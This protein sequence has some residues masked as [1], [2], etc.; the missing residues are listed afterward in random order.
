MAEGEKSGDERLACDEEQPSTSSSRKSRGRV[1]SQSARERGQEEA[2]GSG[3]SVRDR[4]RS[5]HECRWR[6]ESEPDTEAPP[7]P[8]F[9]P[10]RTPG[11]QPPLNMGN[12]S[13]L[14]IFSSFFDTAV[15]NL[16][17]HNTNKNAAGKIAQGKRF[18]WRD[19]TAED[20]KKFIGMLLFMSV[21]HLPKLSDY[22]R[23][24]T[25]FQVPFPATIMPRDQFMSILSCIHMSDPEEDKI[26]EEKKGT[27]DYDRLHRVRP[28]MDLISMRCKAIYHPRQHLSVD[29]RMVATKARLGIKQY[30][31]AKPTKWGLK[32]FVLADVN[33]Y[34]IDFQL[35]TG[36]AEIFSGHG[37]S[38]DVVCSLVQ[39]SYLG[40][41]YVIYIDNFYTSPL[42][43]RHL[44]QLGFGAC[45]TYRKGRVG[46]PTTHENALTK[47][48]PR[49]SIRWIRDRDLLYIKWMDTREVSMC[50]TLH[51]VYSGDVVER[52]EKGPDGTKQKV[53][54]PRPTTVT[55]YNKHMGG[56]DTSDQMITTTSVHRKTMR[57]TTTVF[58]H[59]ID[60]AA[61]NSFVVHKEQCSIMQQKP[62]TRQAFTEE[63]AVSL[64][65][66]A[67]KLEPQKAPA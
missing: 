18:M 33:G 15:L 50:S 11:V 9:I 41:G 45:G 60:I 32:F 10:K 59:L 49:G 40:S 58:Q 65:G 51:S 27:R 66:A 46:V 54:V 39:K 29:E 57:W 44:R 23:K 8:K 34:T 35:Y 64:M 21:V 5:P 53:S 55:E 22:W 36:K 16:L 67:L 52:W 31:K 20:M 3:D 19:T 48:S 38:F 43:F 47:K 37:L 62:R 12:P 14:E 42:L 24:G 26:Q 2:G 28:L 17:C 25:A 1:R 7:P 30:M 4:S 56:V 63:L 61:T 13:P 6:S